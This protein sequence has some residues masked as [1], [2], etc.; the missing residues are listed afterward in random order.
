MSVTG[1]LYFNGRWQS[2]EGGQYQ[3]ENPATGLPI[4]PVLTKA[5]EAQVSEALAAAQRALAPYQQTSPVDRASFLNAIADEIMALGDQLTERVC[6]ET[7]YP[8]MRAEGERARTCGQLRMFADFVAKGDHLDA[9]IDTADAARKPAPKP[10]TRYCNQAL[11]PVAVFGASNFPLAFSV[12]GGDTAS[13]LAAGCPVIVKGHSSHPGTC[14][15]VAQAI[16]RAALSCHMPPGVFSLVMGEGR[17]VGSALVAAPEIKAVGFTGSLQG[18]MALHKLANTRQE[19]IPVFAEMGSLNPVVLLPQALDS[20]CTG[21]AEGFVG[22]LTLGVGQFCVNPGVVLALDTPELEEFFT[23]TC[24]A[25]AQVDSGIMLNQRIC[26]AYT[27]STEALQNTNG[28]TILASGQATGNS[29]GYPAQAMLAR[30]SA[31][32][33]IS[34]V[35]LREEIFG[36]VSLVVVCRD[37]DELMAAISC[38]SGQLTGTIHA[39]EGEL[40]NYQDLTDC[41]RARVGRL[42]FNGFPTGVEVCPSMVHGGPF[43]ASTDTRFTSVGT[44]AIERF[45]RPVCF[46][47]APNCVLPDALKDDNPLNIVR[48]VNNNLTQDPVTR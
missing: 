15:L 31:E 46:Q 48:R 4:D 23:A 40:D 22:S 17:Q 24:S 13:A 1:N 12:A 45:L 30:T 9:R 38:L 20:N 19:P 27:Q 7:G 3:A 8:K 43:P 36:P 42:V 47:D 29:A 2:G 37:Q 33:F 18:G 44:A 11:G 6:Q 10:D 16:A 26:D 39:A 41:L 5:S 34:N 35:S 32:N 14:E 28:V 25:L 21:I